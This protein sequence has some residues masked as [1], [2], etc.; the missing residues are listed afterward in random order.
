M[1]NPRAGGDE[2]FELVRTFPLRPIR[3]GEESEAAGKVLNRLL[4]QPGGRLTEGQRDYLQARHTLLRQVIVEGLGHAWS[5]GDG[6]FQFN[7]D[8]GPD[9]SRMIL[10]FL[11][12][13]Q[14][15]IPEIVRVG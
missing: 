4:G 5:G 14:R 3:N 12:R 15:E 6:S 11:M 9:A 8:A 13:H 1:S 10:D 7:D 2:Y